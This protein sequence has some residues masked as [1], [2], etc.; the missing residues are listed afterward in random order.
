VSAAL[1]AW[2]AALAVALAERLGHRTLN[3]ML[4]DPQILIDHENN[5]VW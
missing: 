4:L 3:W 5:I 2:T 1:R